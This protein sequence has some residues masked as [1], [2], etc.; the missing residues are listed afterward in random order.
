MRLLT[1]GGSYIYA[2]GKVKC[3]SYEYILTLQY[4]V[5]EDSVL[6]IA[7]SEYYIHVFDI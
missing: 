6:T 5:V 7:L 4:V 1:N 3:N 2:E